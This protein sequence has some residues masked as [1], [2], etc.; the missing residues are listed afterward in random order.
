MAPRNDQRMPATQG[1]VIAANVDMLVGQVDIGEGCTARTR[2]EW[3]G[4]ACSILLMRLRKSIANG[5][6]F[7]YRSTRAAEP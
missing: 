3:I 1:T 2:I 4:R 7:G 6:G 5:N